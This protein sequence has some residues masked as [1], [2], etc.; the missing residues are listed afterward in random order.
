[1]NTR[2]PGTAIE[3]WAWPKK[4]SG[5]KAWTHPLGPIFDSPKHK[6]KG[7]ETEGLTFAPYAVC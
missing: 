4:R 5:V 7:G 6:M 3:Y 2:N 1:M